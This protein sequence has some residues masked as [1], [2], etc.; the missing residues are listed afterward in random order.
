MAFVAY[1]SNLGPFY[2]AFFGYLKELVVLTCHDYLFEV[3]FS[4]K[5]SINS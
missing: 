1:F 3:L 5:I 2:G 4:I